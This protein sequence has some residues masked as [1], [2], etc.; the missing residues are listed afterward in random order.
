MER[1][2]DSKLDKKYRGDLYIKNS[3]NRSYRKSNMATTIAI[4]KICF[5]FF[6]L[7]RTA[8]GLETSF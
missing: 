2:I 1:P 7:N 3:L 5:H 6:L 8:N 4:L